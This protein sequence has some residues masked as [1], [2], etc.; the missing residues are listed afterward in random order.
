M[1]R[2]ALGLVLCGMLL[3]NLAFSDTIVEKKSKQEFPATIEVEYDGSTSTLRATGAALR[4]KIFWKVYAA[5]GYIDSSVELGDD[6]G[7]AIVDADA[8]KEIHLRMLRDV[9]SKKITNGVNEA[10]K[11]CAVVPYDDIAGEREQF[12]NVFGDEKL[13]KGDDLRMLYLPGKGLEVSVNGEVRGV[14]E[15]AGFGRSFFAI[16]YG[17]P[18]VDD[19]LKE[20]LLSAV[21]EDQD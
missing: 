16:Y 9:D 3:P 8:P 18:P 4:K 19:G 7:K 11:K 15:G 10:L 6:P 12:L 5:V 20:K 2:R 1:M 13:M 21:T 14:I 17:D